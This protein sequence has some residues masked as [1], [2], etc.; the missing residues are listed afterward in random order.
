MSPSG[1][2]GGRVL[3]FQGAKILLCLLTKRKELM[4]KKSLKTQ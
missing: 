2:S 3:F 1:I 4:Q